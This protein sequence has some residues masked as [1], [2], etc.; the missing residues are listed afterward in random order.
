MLD[1]K[2]KK[3]VNQLLAIDYRKEGLQILELTTDE[4]RNEFLKY[5]EKDDT[6]NICCLV[7]DSAKDKLV[8]AGKSKYQRNGFGLLNKYHENI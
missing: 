6:H 8:E 7:L 1:P 5:W 3:I 4:K 2:F